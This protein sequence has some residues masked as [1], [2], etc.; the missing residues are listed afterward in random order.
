MTPSDYRKER[1]SLIR[2][3][4]AKIA[5][6]LWVSGYS[7]G[8]K[9]WAPRNAKGELTNKV[10]K[11]NGFVVNE[12]EG[13]TEHGVITDGYGGGLAVCDYE[14]MPLEDLFKLNNWMTRMLPRLLAAQ[15]SKKE[16]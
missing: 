5:K 11:L 14:C 4:K 6:H 10:Y 16:A 8:L 9:L 15:P 1:A 2:S 3:I 13:F 12:M 7:G